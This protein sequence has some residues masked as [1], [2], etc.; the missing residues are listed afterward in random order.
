MIATSSEYGGAVWKI[1]ESLT[2]NPLSLDLGY[3]I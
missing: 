2:E 3:D 1:S